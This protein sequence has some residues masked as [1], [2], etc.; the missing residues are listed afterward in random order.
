M[1]TIKVQQKA[2]DDDLAAP[3][4]RLK[5]RKCNQRLSPTLKS[6]EPTIQLE[7]DAL[8]LTPFYN[9]FDISAD[10]PE[11][12]MKEFWVTITKHHFSLRFKMNGK[13]H[14]VN[15]D[16]F[17]DMLKI[18]PKLLG[19]KFEDPPFEEEILSFIRDLGH[20]GEIKVLSD[21]NVNHF[22]QPW[23]SFAAIINKCLNG[24]TTALESL[25]LLKPTRLTLTCY[26]TG[27][28]DPKPKP[29]KK[30][31]DCSSPK[32]KPT[33]ASKGKRLKTSAKGVKHAKKKQSATK[34]KGLTVLSEVA[35]TKAEQM[36]IALKR[37]KTQQHNSHASGSDND[38]DDFVHPKL[39]THDEKDK[40]EAELDPKVH[41]P[42]T[43]DEE[44]QGANV[45]GEEMDEEETNEED[46]AN[47][48][49]RDVNLNNRV[50]LYV[51]VTTIAEPPLLSIATLPSPPNPLITHLQ[52]TPI[53][54]P[55][56]VLS[57]SLQDLPNFGSLFRFDHR[58]KTLE[59]DFSKLKQTNQ[60]AIA[61]SSI[62]G[63]IDAYLANKMHE[64]VKTAV[65]L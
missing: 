56:T 42:S 6:N 29:Q 33:Q 24:K 52:Q 18:C 32:T 19:Q 22:H 39:S 35:L 65:P 15:V 40:E 59:T 31:N 11:I 28:K 41:T 14:T 60:F 25:H 21:V 64:A 23:R 49:Y 43:D 45:E 63:I 30:K 47:E 62:P 4:N 26:D 10:V 57:Y 37:S 61:V 16:N 2:L 17:V 9:A 36:K 1:D 51:L 34:S 27:E 12:N 46:E 13:S 55:A 38:G 5:I 48:L 20:T 8:K 3:K 44:I 58:L 7:L 54:T 50:L 53:P